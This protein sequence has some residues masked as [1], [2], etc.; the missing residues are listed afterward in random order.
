MKLCWLIIGLTCVCFGGEARADASGVGHVTVICSD[1]FPDQGVVFQL[2]ASL[3]TQC[4]ANTWIYYNYGYL[5]QTPM[6]LDKLKAVFTSI[7]ASYL[8][9]RPVFISVI[10]ATGC[11]ASWV[12]P[13]WGP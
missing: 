12:R 8:A 7:T 1:C 10:G 4:P 5:G 3:G 2:D 13:W 9:S 6:P 11:N